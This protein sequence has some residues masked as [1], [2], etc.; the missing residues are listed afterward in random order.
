MTCEQL[1]SLLS[2]NIQCR[3]TNIDVQIINYFRY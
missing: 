1:N 2:S 3:T